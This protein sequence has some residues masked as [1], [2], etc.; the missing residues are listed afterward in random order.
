MAIITLARQVAALGDEVGIALAQKLNYDFIKRTDIEKRILELG[1][2]E[3][4]LP[5]YDER[6]PG[7]FASLIKDRDEYFNLTQY[8]LL[9]AA[10]KNNVVIIG[11]GAFVLF[12]NVPNHISVR[13]VADEKTRLE[14]LQK[15][16]D[17][18]EKQARQRIIKSDENRNG[19]HKNFY[20]VDVD[21]P[22]NFDMVLN[23]S[24]VSVEKCA[25]II[26]F[27]AKTAFT[28][29][30]DALCLEKVNMMMQAQTVVNKLIFE[31][32]IKI[33]FL[34]AS[35]EDKTVVL[36]GVSSSDAIVEQ[37]LRI[38]RSEM[39]G[40]EAVSSVSIVHNYKSY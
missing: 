5:K 39:P 4:K 19:F 35:I 29:E 6:K 21:N 34:H 17:W 1:F 11:R 9:E 24:K 32:K 10:Q 26:S 20:N 30:K 33:E 25:E 2:P 28:P 12:A 7:F 22:I 13:L 3:E 14:R 40:Y 37:A 16:F 15:E 27:Y 18:T 8:A 38:I 31:H 23:T 36:Y